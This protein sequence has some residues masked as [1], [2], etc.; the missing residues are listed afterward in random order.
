MVCFGESLS[1]DRAEPEAEGNAY[2]ELLAQDIY[3]LMLT[4]NSTD[5]I[6]EMLDDDQDLAYNIEAL[7]IKINELFSKQHSKEEIIKIIIDN[8]ESDDFFKKAKNIHIF[9]KMILTTGAIVG[10]S[11]V[12]YLLYDWYFKKS[13]WWPSLGKKPDDSKEQLPNDKQ[14]DQPKDP[15]KNQ[16]GGKDQSAAIVDSQALTVESLDHG[17]QADGCCQPP[18]VR[19]VQQLSVASRNLLIQELKLLD[20]YV[21]RNPFGPTQERGVYDSSLHESVAEQIDQAR[22]MGFS[23][24]IK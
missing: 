6:I 2:I 8:K 17:G 3:H 24:R 22:G 20:P 19:D 5:E 14:K 13:W 18:A 21:F 4:G 1:A 16:R 11:Y 10:L 9:L 23:A 12:A 7:V 15:V